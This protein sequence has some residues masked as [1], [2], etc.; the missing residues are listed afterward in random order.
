MTALRWGIGVLSLMLAVGAAGCGG[1]RLPEAGAGRTLAFEPGV[2]NF[3]LEALATWQE[4]TPGVDVYLSIPRLSLV[5][6][7][8]AAGRRYRA[9]FET[10]VRLLD[11]RGRE[12]LQEQLRTDTVQV[13]TYEATRTFEPLLRTLRLEAPPG[14]Y[15]V[16]V[17]LL[18]LESGQQALRRQ[19]V[20]VADASVE[21]ALGG[22]RLEGRRPGAPPSPIVSLHVPADV[23]SLR[24]V[25]E[26]YRAGRAEAATLEMTLLRFE[27]DTSIATPPYYVGP[28]FGSLA[29][30]GLRDERPDTLQVSRRRLAAEAGEAVV[31]FSLPALDPGVYRVRITARPDGPAPG[32]RLERVRDFTVR[33]PWFP[34][35][36]LIDE[37]IEALAYIASERELRD[38]RAGE[39]PWERKRRF[40][41]FWGRLVANRQVAADLIERYYSRI[42]E[43]NLRFS[44]FKE[45][46]K[47]DRGMIYVIFGA[48][49][50]VETRIDAEV[51]HYGYVGDDPLSTF[52]FQRIRPFPADLVFEHYLL[53]RRPYYERPWSRALERW[54]NGSVR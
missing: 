50:Y 52:V 25:V 4:G 46:W 2:P 1:A 37:M 35:L 51:W 49:A 27:S 14:T 31:E 33:S 5:F 34:R 7:E 54:R 22:I 48:P 26:V 45:G 11:A 13:T 21:P 16:D 18:D 20:E 43:A 9:R 6:V 41:A 3:D 12:V 10:L 19:R 23:D 39:T 36:V 44:T 30:R 24:A 38:I 29:Y 17:T 47:T 42:E 32:R 40:D 15:V 28:S 8:E 53:E